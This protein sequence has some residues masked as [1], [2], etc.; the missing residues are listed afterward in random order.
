MRKY[1]YAASIQ[2]IQQYIFQTNRLREIIGA[3][4]LLDNAFSGRGN[5]PSIF[6]QFCRDLDV[7]TSTIEVITAA[8]ANF[9]CVVDDEVGKRIARDFP[10]YL[11]EK[12]PGIQ[13]SQVLVPIE[14]E[15]Q[16]QQVYRQIHQLLQAQRNK[17]LISPDPPFMGVLKSRRTGGAAIVRKKGEYLDL[18]TSAKLNFS[19]EDA[20]P[21]FEDF[22]GLPEVKKDRLPY[23]FK[24]LIKQ[25]EDGDAERMSWIAVVHA[26]GNSIGRRVI[27]LLAER[28][29]H[30]RLKKFSEALANATKRAVNGACREVLDATK[31][32]KYY[33][34]RPIIL[35][36][37]DITLVIRADKA[38]AFVKRYLELFEQYTKEDPNL[39]NGLTACAGVAFI[40]HKFPFHY[41]IDLAEKLTKEAKKASK[42]LDETSPPSSVSIFKVQS[43]YVESLE[44]M[45]KRT[46]GISE[47]LEKKERPLYA[48]PYFLRQP[49]GQGKYALLDDL[50]RHAQAL[51]ESRNKEEEQKALS[52]LRQ[53]IELLK[54]QPERASML[55]SRMKQ[56]NG[57]FCKRLEVENKPSILYD[58]LSVYSMM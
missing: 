20:L 24:E 39:G 36:G 55:L 57:D 7:N 12:V 58:V 13:F 10:K 16:F 21:F 1:L 38:L 56:V 45:R 17:S 49:N 23:S 15:N 6:N 19:S 4:A 54:I 31:E 11:A 50:M 33:I 30:E 47:G 41:G 40:K 3:S 25:T 29:A 48:D 46:Y 2:G 32:E 5:A 53:Y 52:K 9:R 43:S 18:L 22:T 44:E 37:D 14:G 28:D 51:Y 8:A 35:G 34:L 42:G 27:S 26:D